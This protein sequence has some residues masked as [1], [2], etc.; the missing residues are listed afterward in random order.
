MA[1]FKVTARKLEPTKMIRVFE[2]EGKQNRAIMEKEKN[3]LSAH[4]QAEP[5][6]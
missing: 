5:S 3:S 6:P 4:G 1:N 2:P